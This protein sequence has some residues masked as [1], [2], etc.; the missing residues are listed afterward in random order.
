LST[1]FQ[2]ER[3]I[4]GERYVNGVYQEAKSFYIPTNT[5]TL[6]ALAYDYRHGEVLFVDDEKPDTI[7]G[8]SP[9]LDLHLVLYV[10]GAQ[11]D[12]VATGPI[13]HNLYFA[14]NSK[15]A[16]LKTINCL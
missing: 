6:R 14:D 9:S 15:S 1:K 8:G 4:V 5:T 10:K 13:T 2:E 3:R 16:L 12:C 7:W 11:F